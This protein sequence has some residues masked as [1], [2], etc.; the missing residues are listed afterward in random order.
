MNVKVDSQMSA[1]IIAFKVINKY[2]N[3]DVKMKLDE[4]LDEYERA[5]EWSV[6][7]DPVLFRFLVEDLNHRDFDVDE[8]E[9]VLIN[10]FF[11]IFQHFIK[12][13]PM[14]LASRSSSILNLLYNEFPH[15]ID[16]KTVE[17]VKEIDSELS[18]L[19]SRLGEK[20]SL[21]GAVMFADEFVLRA[22]EAIARHKL[23]MRLSRK[24][25]NYWEMAEIAKMYYLGYKTV[26]L[27]LSKN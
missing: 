3:D 16:K 18:F 10:K 5:L 13:A 22:N 14:G 8:L 20:R 11:Q 17:C 24:N 27:E 6:V 12:G 25:K 26:K 21:K 2:A 7:H 1:Y 23:N 19:L 15:P 4:L 9:T